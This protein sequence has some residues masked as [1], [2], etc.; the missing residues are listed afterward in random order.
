MLNQPCTINMPCTIIIFDNLAPSVR[1]LYTVR[2]L[3]LAVFFS[4]VRLK[5]DVRLFGTRE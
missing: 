3:I 1:L 5:A 4:S 2:L